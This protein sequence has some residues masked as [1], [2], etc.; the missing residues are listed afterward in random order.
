MKVKRRFK[1]ELSREFRG[2]IA[3]K[4]KA[5]QTSITGETPLAGVGGI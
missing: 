2:P 5:D 4:R 3:D 1:M